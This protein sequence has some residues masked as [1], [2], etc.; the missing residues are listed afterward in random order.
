M[1]GLEV[2][3]NVVWIAGVLVI[4]FVLQ[5]RHH[6]AEKA[7]EAAA[8][9]RARARHTK[10]G[11]ALESYRKQYIPTPQHGGFPQADR[12]GFELLDLALLATEEIPDPPLPRLSE[13]RKIG[14]G[15]LMRVLAVMPGVDEAADLWVAVEDREGDHFGGA[16][17]EVGEPA[18]AAFKGRRIAFHANHIGEIVAAPTG[19][20]H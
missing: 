1:P 18:F 20:M 12:D 11:K 9:A 15:D 19:A 16:V 6:R 8:T 13:K 5:R 10:V 17:H 4:A 3:L 14:A 7:A 2:W